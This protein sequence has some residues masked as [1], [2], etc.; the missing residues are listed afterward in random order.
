MKQ[1]RDMKPE[2]KKFQTGPENMDPWDANNLNYKN[3]N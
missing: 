1:S 2:Q 3:Q